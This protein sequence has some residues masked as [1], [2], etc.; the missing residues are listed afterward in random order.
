MLSPLQFPV[1]HISTPLHSELHHSCALYRAAC[2]SRLDWER[3]GDRRSRLATTYRKYRYQGVRKDQSTVL[4][5]TAEP[6]LQL[7]RVNFEAL[8]TALGKAFRSFPQLNASV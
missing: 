6:V 8:K 4:G 1:V 5:R 2:G 3:L 7:F